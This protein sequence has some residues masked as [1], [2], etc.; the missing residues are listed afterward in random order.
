MDTESKDENCLT[1]GEQETIVDLVK[2]TLEIAIAD[3]QWLSARERKLMFV[4]AVGG[5]SL[6]AHS[7]RLNTAVAELDFLAIQTWPT[8]IKDLYL[9]PLKVAANDLLWSDDDGR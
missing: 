9:P 8:Y 5:A 6:F 7:Q 3:L 4:M 1:K 2:R